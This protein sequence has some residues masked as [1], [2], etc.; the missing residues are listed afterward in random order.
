MV[1]LGPKE[2][3]HKGGT[4]SGVSVRKYRHDIITIMDTSLKKL[5]SFFY[6]LSALAILVVF[7][8]NETFSVVTV[9]G[10]VSALLFVFTYFLIFRI[11]SEK[12]WVNVI[13]IFIAIIIFLFALLLYPFYNYFENTACFDSKRIAYKNIFTNKIV[14][15]SFCSKD[16]KSWY[17]RELPADDPRRNI[18]MPPPLTL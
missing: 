13:R 1:P 14:E 15:R 9:L 17:L 11:N 10:S 3:V 6:I 16:V 5:F 8:G 4:P 7:Y 2:F 12:K 18:G